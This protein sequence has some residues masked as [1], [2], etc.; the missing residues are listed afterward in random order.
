[1]IQNHPSVAE[2]FQRHA[3]ICQE[4][5]D[6]PFGYCARGFA[7]LGRAARMRDADNQLELSLVFQEAEHRPLSRMFLNGVHRDRR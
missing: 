2:E 7:L 5:K 6:N 3:S 1:M 4:C